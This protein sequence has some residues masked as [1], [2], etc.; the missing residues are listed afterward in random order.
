MS[1]KQRKIKFEPRI[2]LNHNTYINGVADLLRW[3][4]KTH[5]SLAGE[6]T[7]ARLAKRKLKL[8]VGI[9]QLHSGNLVAS[10]CGP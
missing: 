4:N 1:L 10:H 5:L 8:Y 6:G 2:K 9:A 3:R 7:N